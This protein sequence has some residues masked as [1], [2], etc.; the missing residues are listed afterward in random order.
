MRLA[1]RGGRMA[2]DA[3]H[4]GTSE[5]SDSWHSYPSIYAL[6]HHAVKDLFRGPVIVEEKIDGS[7]FSFG[8]FD[9]GMRYKSKGA[10][11]YAESPGMFQLAVDGA[12]SR[13]D[14]LHRSEEHT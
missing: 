2:N 13:A 9:D 14:V 7:Q 12:R 10:I 6:G 8:L 5:M 3:E 4:A 11:V 1:G